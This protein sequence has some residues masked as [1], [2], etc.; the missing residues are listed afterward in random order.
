MTVII[1]PSIIF[2]LLFN[3]MMSFSFYILAG[4]YILERRAILKL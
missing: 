2:M 4:S 1:D 3:I